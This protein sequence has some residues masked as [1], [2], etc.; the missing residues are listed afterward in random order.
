MY[1]C[2]PFKQKIRTPVLNKQIANLWFV[3]S[4]VGYSRRLNLTFY[5]LICILT[6]RTVFYWSS[7]SWP[8]MQTFGSRVVANTCVWC[9]LLGSLSCCF[10]PL[11]WLS[12]LRK[13]ALKAV[14]Q[15][16]TPGNF[17]FRFVNWHFQYFC[18]LSVRS[19]PFQMPSQ[20]QIRFV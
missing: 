20:A 19:V 10:F 4:Q 6:A 18:I 7:T 3:R 8:Q 11:G 9:W 14:L 16:R 12:T 17:E 13:V 5:K 15:L 2:Y 1:A